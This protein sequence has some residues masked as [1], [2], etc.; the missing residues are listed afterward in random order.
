VLLLPPNPTT[1]RATPLHWHADLAK[2]TYLAY[3]SQGNV[4]LRDLKDP[5]F[6]RCLIYT[7]FMGKATTV[8]F[9]PNGEWCASGD[10]KGRVKIWK[11][12]EEAKEKWVVKKEHQMLAA[13]V[14]SIA[15]SEDGK[16]ISAGGDGKDQFAK[17][18][19]TET[20]TKQGDIIGPTK[21]VISI[22]L[23]QTGPK[24]M[25]LLVGGENNEITV[26][27]G[28]PF[29][30]NKTLRTHT[31]FI[32]KIAFRPDG[33][34]FVSVSADK[35]IAIYDTETLEVVRKIDKAHNKGIIDAV[36]VNDNTIATSS[37]DNEVK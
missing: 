8:Q 10:D 27:D 21:R 37:S 32:N 4:V 24:S 18:I 16:H 13:P 35:S 22:D 23:K 3:P 33:L 14:S 17:A 25:K 12:D 34:F 6:G 19:L 7:D 2:G 31:G 11:Y 1:T 29:K 15:W 5:R 36:W 20:G 30:F 26:F 9:S 28:A